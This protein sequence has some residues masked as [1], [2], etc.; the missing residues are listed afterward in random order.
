MKVSAARHARLL[1][2]RRSALLV[3][4]RLGTF[5]TDG[6]SRF[7]YKGATLSISHR[8]PFSVPFPAASERDKYISA[9]LGIACPVDLPYGLDV[10]APR[11]VL[12]VEWDGAGRVQLIGYKPGPWED[13]LRDLANRAPHVLATRQG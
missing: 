11:K 1:H 8:T 10:W 13:E 2:I 5:S 6:S 7:E 3:L 4:G 9:V 12:N